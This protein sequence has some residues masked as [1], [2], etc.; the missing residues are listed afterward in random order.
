MPFDSQTLG[1]P[2]DIW[3][4]CLSVHLR[5]RKVNLRMEE[6]FCPSQI[7]IFALKSSKARPDFQPK[8][9]TK[10]T[11]FDQTS[12]NGTINH[13]ALWYISITHWKFTN[14]FHFQSP[15]SPLLCFFNRHPKLLH[16]RPLLRPRLRSRPFS[17]RSRLRDLAANSRTRKNMAIRPS[18][19]SR[20]G[21]WEKRITKNHWESLMLTPGKL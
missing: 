19:P 8:Q 16:L 9:L 5:R 10:Y 11:R 20:N 12:K 15:L 13:F 18:F 7:S 17:P 3:T 14:L 4:L 6:P 2:H 21:C 1:N